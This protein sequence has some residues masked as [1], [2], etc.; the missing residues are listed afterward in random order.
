MY[1]GKTPAFY[2]DC[3]KVACVDQSQFWRE[4]IK[5]FMCLP[6]WKEN[7][8]RWLLFFV[9]ASISRYSVSLSNFT[10]PHLGTLK[11]I[12]S[13]M[14]H[15][16]QPSLYEPTALTTSAQCSPSKKLS[17]CQCARTCQC[18]LTCQFARTCQCAEQ[19]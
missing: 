4:S 9:Q 13:L 6:K 17:T 19:K 12:I 3:L 11:K 1:L 18:A 14:E 7:R 8:N 5:S 10:I 16:R 2:P 15:N